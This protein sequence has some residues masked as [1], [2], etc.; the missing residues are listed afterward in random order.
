[1]NI[2]RCIPDYPTSLKSILSTTTA[3]GL[4]LVAAAPAIAQEMLLEEIQVTAQKRSQ[5]VQDV[6]IAITALSGDQ[7]RALGYTNAQ[8]VTALAPGVSTVQPNGEANYAVAI[9]GVANSDFTTNVE[10]PVAIYVDEVYISQM[11]GTGF[12]LF[13]M[14]RVEVL[15][16][17]QGT[18][19]GRNATG[20]LVQFIT[21][22]PTEEF[23]GYAS[24][25][26]GSW[27]RVKGEA[28]I[29]GPVSENL[30]AR[31]SVTGHKGGGY[32]ENRL[33]DKD[34]NNVNDYAGRLQLLFKPTDTMDILLNVRGSSQ[35]IRTGFFEHA[36]AIYPDS[37]PTPGV[38]N[39]NLDGYTDTDGDV[40]AGDYNFQ[41]YNDLETMGYTATI[42]WDV[43]SNM[44]LTS[45][46][47]YQTVQRN[48]IEDSDSSPSD[49]FN[50]F[51][52]TDSK[53]FSQE[54]RLNGTTDRMKWVTGFYYLDLDIDDSNGTVARDWFKDALPALFGGTQEEFGGLNGIYNPYS[55][56]SESWSIFAD[57]EYDLTDTLS[58][59][60]GFR[61]IEE[62]KTMEYRDIGVLFT[63]NAEAAPIENYTELFDLVMPYSGERDDGNW[64][65]R[66]QLNYKPNSDLLTYLSWNRGVKSGSFNAPVL[67]TDIL[68]TD[69]FMNYEPEKLDAF[70][71]GFKLDIPDS[72][73]RIN[74]AAYYYD[75]KNY[76][77]FSIVGL[78]TFTLNTQAKNKGFEL[79]VFSS[80][81]PGLDLMAGVGYIDSEVTDIPGMTIDVETPAG[82]AEAFLPGAVLTSVQTPKWNL[83]GLARYEF[84]VGEGSMSV[85]TDFQYRSKHYFSLLQSPASTEKG[86]AIFNASA[87][88]MNADEDWEVR[89]SVDNLFNEKYRVQIF[90]LSGNIDNGGLFFGMIEEYYGRPRSWRLSV[91]HNF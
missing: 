58:L 57:I 77:G 63:D 39:S 16:G 84:A 15:R 60:G 8:Q 4:S 61:W 26:Y 38:P 13:D 19:F 74:G 87:A 28:A 47:D 78:D 17:P 89:F 70:E 66:V 3:I 69:T 45:L 33:S 1:M 36:T 34:L 49:Y 80:P 40:Y 88:W 14:E 18:L 35:D 83:N 54:L 31:V 12:Q 44:T 20:G 71:A 6:G 85:Q 55:L 53:Q 29:S 32:I 23:E 41:G 22:K 42:S 59:T 90:D 75:Y 50:F 72:N 86:Y 5:S 43:S 62:D 30:S 10:S 25:S 65:A 24:L 48:Y 2:T 76:Q 7:M 56:Q 11:S 64:S 91:T 79:E 9:R 68:V 37:T 51:L 81:A 52:T 27:N 73:L 21:K 46:T 67:P 82:T